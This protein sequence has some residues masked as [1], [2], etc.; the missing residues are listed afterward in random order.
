MK[1]WNTVTA[2]FQAG[3]LTVKDIERSTLGI[4]YFLGI[5]NEDVR[6]ALA[7]GL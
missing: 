4:G 6:Q 2:L 5:P 3:R 1:E 7:Q